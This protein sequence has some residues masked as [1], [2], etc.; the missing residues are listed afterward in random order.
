MYVMMDYGMWLSRGS[1]VNGMVTTALPSL[2]KN[3]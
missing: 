3:K 2:D 1:V